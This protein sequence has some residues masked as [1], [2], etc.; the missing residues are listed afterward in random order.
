M[1]QYTRYL[2]L[3]ST[4]ENLFGSE[5]WYALKE[6]NHLPTWK[7][8]LQ[9]VVRAI[10]ISILTT[11]KIYDEEWIEQINDTVEC[12]QKNIIKATDIEEAIAALSA[13]LINISF[14]QVGFMPNRKGRPKKITLKKENWNLDLY[15]TVMYLQTEEQKEAVFWSKQQ[16]EIGF[17][18]QIEMWYKYRQLKS[19][20]S[21]SKW[22]KNVGH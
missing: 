7:K 11:V 19:N 10:H 12:G 15:R 20:I 3:K 5:S 1:N 4:I 6:S 22:C 18:C 17:S 8:Q 13:T 21:Y 9:K 2:S 14:L 16:K